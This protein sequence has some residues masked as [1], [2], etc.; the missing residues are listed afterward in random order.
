[1]SINDTNVDSVIAQIDILVSSAVVSWSD[2]DY[3]IANAMNQLSGNMVDV[4]NVSRIDIQK[5]MDLSEVSSLTDIQRYNWE[6]IMNNESIPVRD[7]T[8]RNQ[9][10]SIW[11]GGSNTRTNFAALQTKSSTFI[12]DATQSL[13]DTLTHLKVAEL[14]KIKFEG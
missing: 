11:P 13:G 12:E 7:Q 10:L 1:M 9:V 14:R 5:A 2:P 6:L 3:I 8:I 4:D